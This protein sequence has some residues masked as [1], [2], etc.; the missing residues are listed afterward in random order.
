MYVG[1]RGGLRCRLLIVVST[2]LV[3]ILVGTAT[4]GAL[5]SVVVVDGGCRILLTS[6]GGIGNVAV[7]VVDVAVDTVVGIA[8]E[9]GAVGVFFDGNDDAVVVR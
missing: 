1:M 6:F 5:V 3:S 2:T 4:V 7:G 9:C 8:A